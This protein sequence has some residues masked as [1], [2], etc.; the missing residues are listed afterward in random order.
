M[1]AITFDGVTGYL[2][3]AKTQA[4]GVVLL[5]TIFGVNPFVRDFASA[6]ATDGITTLIWDI[7]SGEALPGGFDE[8]RER[9]GKL[10]DG[11]S[12]TAMGKCVDFLANEL[13]VAAIG[14]I[15]FCLGGRYVLTLGAHDK[16]LGAC[17]SVYPSIPG[18]PDDDAVTHAGEIACPVQVIYPG[19]DYIT[20][21]ETFQRLQQTLQS[22]PS[23]A[24]VMQLHPLA[25][26]GFMHNDGPENQLAD[27]QARPLVAPFLTACLG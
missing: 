22:R 2:V 9:A 20:S 16:R 23:A 14:T 7:Y 17:V 1:S 15:G 10:R 6:L 26:H 11:S 4:A 24:T 12:L 5:P 21:N 25:A 13:R 3:R 18:G 19:R 8:A 27:R